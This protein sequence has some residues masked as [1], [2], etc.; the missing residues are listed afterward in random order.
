MSDT[1]IRVSEELAEELHGRKE[2]GDS[3]EDV[4]WRLIEQ[5]DSGAESDERSGTHEPVETAVPV[6]E[7]EPG[8]EPAAD[9]TPE[10][11]IPGSGANAEA[12]RETIADMREYLREHGSATREELVALVDPDAVGYDSRESFWSNCVKGRE[13]LRAFEDVS[14]PGR[15]G[16]TW[17]YCGNQ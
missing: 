16:S 10:L 5:A 15:G 11:D 3:Y 2:R 1:T 17:R 14:S 4:I 13:T 12:R 9:A 7:S 6:L 8:P